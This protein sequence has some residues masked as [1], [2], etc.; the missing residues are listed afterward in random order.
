ML[1]TS[2]KWRQHAKEKAS[3]GKYP[4]LNRMNEFDKLNEIETES[5]KKK[6]NK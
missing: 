4:F 1:C 6:S 3:E 5:N 2:V